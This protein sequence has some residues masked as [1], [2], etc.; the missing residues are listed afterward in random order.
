MAALALPAAALSVPTRCEA[1]SQKGL[2]IV[3]PQRFH[4]ALKDYASHRAATLPCRLVALER[5]LSGSRGRDDAEKLK[6]YL[7]AAWRTEGIGYVLLVG[8]PELLPIRYM[9]LDRI[10]PEAFNYAFYPSDL[11][12]GDV[13]R[14]DGSFD[15]WN[16]ST[17]SFHRDYYGEVRGEAN[18]DD[19]MNYDGVDYRPEIAVGRWPARDLSDVRTIARKSIAYE[20]SLSEPSRRSPR[21][22]LFAVGGWVDSRDMM[23]SLATRLSEPWEARKRYYDGDG[24]SPGTPPPDRDRLL[25]DFNEGVELIVHAGH[26]TDTE[27]E[28]CFSVAD[29]RKINNSSRVPVVFSV[30]CNT[31]RFATL[32]PY[33]PYTDVR[34]RSHRGTNKGEK[35]SSPPP[36]PDVYQPD[37]LYT[38]GFGDLLLRQSLNGAVAYIGCDTGA[39][40]CALTLLDGFITALSSVPSVRIGDCWAAAVS[41]YWEAENLAGLKPDDGWYPASIFF[42]GM[43][44]NLF[45]DPSLPM[46]AGASKR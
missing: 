40:P 14:Q 44:F 3:A 42:Q 24:R 27:W 38:A 12:Y 25:G 43:K 46:P 32:P 10:T 2:L 23:D 8:S 33:E 6:R 21:A 34:G 19:P 39:Q 22:A 16:G 37:K 9:A 4:T 1:A 30:G 20:Q 5:V 29:L 35:F 18:K 15:D 45:G 13:A 26:G 7:Y 36:P 31:G 17:S 41:H 28:Q 11:Y